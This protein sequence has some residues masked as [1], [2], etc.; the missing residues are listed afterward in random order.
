[1]EN[2]ITSTLNMSGVVA[3]A[4]CLLA[5]LIT[6]IY[7]M[8]N[9]IN[10]IPSATGT[11]KSQQQ[12]MTNVLIALSVTLLVTGIAIRVVPGL[13]GFGALF[14]Q[15]SNVSYFFLFTVG[16]ILFYGAMPPKVIADYAYMF[17]PLFF[18][19]GCVSLVASAS[20]NYVKEYR[21]M[22]YERI[23]GM[24]MLCCMLALIITLY[25][26]NPGGAVSKYFGFSMVLT[27]VMTVFAMVY[28]I[29][30]ATMRPEDG[31]VSSP[32]LLPRSSSFGMYSFALFVVFLVVTAVAMSQDKT[33][34][35]DPL[36]SASMIVV[37]LVAC[38]V[39]LTVIAFH[40]F[41][42]VGQIMENVTKVDLYK[43]ALLFLL[44]VVLF[45][46]FIAWLVYN[47]QGLSTKWG[48]TNF[49]LNLVLLLVIASMV[50]KTVVVEFPVGNDKKNAFFGFIANFLFFLECIVSGVFD[51]LTKFVVY[52]KCVFQ[53]NEDPF[54]VIVTTIAF[55]IFY[56]KTPMLA[57]FMSIQ[58]GK[59]L[60]NRPVYTD[61]QYVL[62]N[63][64]QLTGNETFDYHFGISCWLFIDAMP[65]NTNTNYNRFTSLL[66]FGNKPN[67]VYNASKNELRVTM[68]QR[69]LKQ[70]VARDKDTL[71][72]F[73]Q[74]D[75]RILFVQK[76]VPLQKWNNLIINYNS[77][78]LDIF[79][80]GELVKSSQEV[81]PYYTFDNLTIGENK[82]IQ[83][84]ICNVV[85][86]REPLTASNVY[87]IY[88]TLKHKT[89]PVLNDSAETI[90][91]NI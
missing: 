14:Q 88:N 3:S 30:L 86:F 91:Y 74:D 53:G 57:N 48:I 42:D 79:L 69:D 73:D 61:T 43:K 64:Q 12:T 72:E 27:I 75:N 17:N 82:G 35:Q 5:F 46:L 55:L 50:Y 13:M 28:V 40:S 41:N 81:V 47:I 68:E 33:F 90:I 8:Y 34:F 32:N 70:V 37:L 51:V 23:K 1:M 7:V 20:S 66:N 44:G 36:R 78:T 85:Y 54:L 65:P 76:D 52:M 67:V 9:D 58:G 19:V 26:L 77:G 22:T 62:G 60:V 16:T 56:F 2:K 49:V 89:P 6:M 21:N 80:N 25:V 59:Q 39:W 4:V 84:G 15:I 38:I 18:V 87:Y 63:Y 10:L 31:G 24:V 29:V 83:G 45:G 11:V 71:V